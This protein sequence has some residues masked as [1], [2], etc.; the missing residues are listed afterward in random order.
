MTNAL[1]RRIRDLG[2]AG[3]AGG[4]I[5]CASSERAAPSPAKACEGVE[6]VVAASNREGSSV[7]CGA[8]VCE[9]NERTTGADLGAD[10]ALSTSN[11]RAF[12]VARD[13]DLI[14]ELDAACGTPK[15]KIGIHDF[16]TSSGGVRRLANAHDVA[17]APDGTLFVTLFGTGGLGLVKDGAV[18]GVL[19]LS[20]YDDDGNPN[21]ESICIVDVDGKPKAFVALELLDNR[22]VRLPPKRAARML[23]VDVETRAVER[24]VDLIGWNPFNAM[25]QDDGFLYLAVPRNFDAA[26]EP[27][28][29]IERFDT[30]TET[31]QLVVAE[32]DLGA[33]VVEVAVD[34]GCGVAIVAGPEPT[35]NPTSIVTF[36][37]NTGV[38]ATKTDAPLLATEGYDLQGLTFRGD[39]L[40]VGDRRS[41]SGG[42]PVHVF[43]RATGTCTFTPA[44]SPI[45]LPQKPVAIR[46]AAP[47]R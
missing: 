47:L 42:Y 31:S 3:L 24:V 16:A 30:R 46:A 34:R 6:L 38:V 15:A 2:V 43:D 22:E 5:A 19:D 7:V 33:S 25:A 9:A 11:G 44:G 8:P 45:L 20:A 21:P 40:Y 26:D 1:R 10:P 36:D 12:F 41:V 27:F 23:R 39:K 13:K 18:A 17:A 28:A 32:T 14:F 35:I 37:A 29:G 4:A